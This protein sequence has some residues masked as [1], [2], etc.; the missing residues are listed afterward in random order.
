MTAILFGSIGTVA[1]TSEL[2]RKAFNQAFEAHG[3]DW[4]WD[5]HDYVAMLDHSGGQARITAYAESLGQEVDAAAIHETK[6]KIFQNTLAT[7][8][9]TPRP[10]VI[11]TVEK[12]RREGVKLALVTTTSETN[13]G[14][15]IAA[16]KPTVDIS[17]FDLV[18]DSSHV[19]EAKPD[20]AAYLFALDRLDEPAEACVAIEDNVGGVQSAVAAGLRVVAFPNENTAGHRFDQ[21][22]GRVDRL[23]FS[24][25]HDLT[26]DAI[27]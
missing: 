26:P 8:G 3:L 4:H 11:E 12:A 10:G 18:V 24:E 17:S 14:A 1:D 23:D 20:K 15:L 13:V 21:A 19:K 5:R 25:L 2:Q 6:S 22:S 16:M 7:G 27:A 9:F